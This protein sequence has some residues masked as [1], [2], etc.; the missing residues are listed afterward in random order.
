MKCECGCGLPCNNR[1]V[2]GHNARLY[3]S[4]EQ[5]RRGKLNYGV[6]KGNSTYYRKIGGRHEHRIVMEK[7][8]G[9]PL[10]SSEVVHHIDGNRRN[11]H[12]DNLEM[13]SRPDHMNE[14]REDLI[15]G[16]REANRPT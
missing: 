12:I 9:R 5:S 16:K 1:F 7:H 8:L 2:S 10:L 13:M 11:N 3:T 15:R 14:H 4:E 6:P